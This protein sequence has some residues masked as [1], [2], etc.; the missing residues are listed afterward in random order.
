MKKI[1]I[2]SGAGYAGDRLEPALELME[3][4]NLD[5]IIFECLAERTIAIAQEQKIKNPD[6]GY[7]GLLEYRMDKV[8]P[9]CVEKRVKVITNMGAA[10]PQAAAAVIKRMAEEKGIERLKIASVLGDDIYGDIEKYMDY[11]VL[12]LE[13]KLENIKDQIVSANVYI[14]ADGVVEAL[15]NGA[16]IVVTGRI[17]D[18]ALVLAPIMHEFGWTSEEYDKI[19][20]GIMIGHL[21]ECAGQ[22]TGGYFADP[23]YK[24]VSELWKLGFPIA[25]ID[26]NGEVVITKVEG[27]GGRVTT[28]TCKEQLIYEI[29]DPAAYVTPDGIADYSNIT[30]KEIAPDRVEVKGAVGREKPDTLKVSIGYRDCYIG[31]GEMSYGGSGAYER[32]KLAGEI[33]KKRLEYT[34]VNIEELRIDYIGINSLYKDQIS[35]AMFENRSACKEVRLR[36]SG[37]TAERSD[38]VKIGNEVEALY[39]NGPAGGGGATQGVKEIISIASIFVPREDIKIEVNYEEV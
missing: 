27:S 14:G 3:K 17:A 38:A 19:G 28:Q 24:D 4:G 15:T 20:K 34:G 22:I 25:E 37:R 1:R 13:T 31:E 18:P 7:N 39:T 30:M 5:Y 9:L 16:D 11:D 29:H 21:L 32:A 33:V 8:L 36:V 6:K 35:D 10:N 23:G 26:E 2:G 12:E